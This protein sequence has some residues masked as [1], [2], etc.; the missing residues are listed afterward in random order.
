M[1]SNSITK[2]SQTVKNGFLNE[3]DIVDKFNHWK[4]HEDAQKWLAIIQYDLKQIE[5]VQ[6]IKSDE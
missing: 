2:G 5:Y 1:K 3:D 6:A 4:T